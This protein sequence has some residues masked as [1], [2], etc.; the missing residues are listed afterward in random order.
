[1][2]PIIADW[3]VLDLLYSAWQTTSLLLQPLKCRFLILKSGS[4]WH[5]VTALSCNRWTNNAE[6]ADF[7]R[8][9]SCVVYGAGT[10][11]YF[12][13]FVCYRQHVAKARSQSL[14]KAKKVKGTALIVP[15]AACCRQS[16]LLPKPLSWTFVCSHTAVR[17]A[18]AC[19]LMIPAPVIHVIIWITTYLPAQRMEGWVG[20]VGWPIA[21]S[22]PKVTTCQQQIGHRSGQSPTYWPLSYA[23]NTHTHTHTT[24]LLET[25]EMRYFIDYRAS[26]SL[27]SCSYWK[28]K[29]P[30]ITDRGN[31]F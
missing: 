28:L 6:A 23:A 27:F 29:L 4:G 5:F 16:R 18:I 30:S 7:A 13:L 26:F 9:A 12:R 24:I 10:L 1:M 8:R 21:D 3:R 14:L 31:T 17:I 25:P 15:Q 2:T 22:V 20:P 19:R 11:W